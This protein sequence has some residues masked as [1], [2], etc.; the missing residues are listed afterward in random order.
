MLCPDSH[1]I[2]LSDQRR[3]KPPPPPPNERPPNE[4][5]ANEL[6]DGPAAKRW[7]KPPPP[8]P[9]L[10]R[11]GAVLTMCL[12][13]SRAGLLLNLPGNLATRVASRGLVGADE[14]RERART[15][16]RPELVG[17]AGARVRGG[18]GQRNDLGRRGHM[19]LSAKVT[20]GDA[21]R[22]VVAEVPRLERRRL[23]RQMRELHQRYRLRRSLQLQRRL[24]VRAV[25]II[26]VERLVGEGRVREHRL[27]PR[28]CHLQ[29]AE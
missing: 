7:L 23:L 20:L 4:L 8:M 26:V 13:V 2:K 24:G 12:L 11:R 22:R 28:L 17:G 10:K 16:A 15:P 18:D 25:G 27:V 3:L 21:Q 6:R 9:L 19:G 29:V 14:E 1:R 5:R